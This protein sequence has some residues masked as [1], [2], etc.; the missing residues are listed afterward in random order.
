[1]GCDQFYGKL[2]INWKATIDKNINDS[3]GICLIIDYFSF[4]MH[5]QLRRF[6][7]TLEGSI[8]NQKLIG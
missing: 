8:E 2:E 6:N 3:F 4:F 7:D 1:M 5:N